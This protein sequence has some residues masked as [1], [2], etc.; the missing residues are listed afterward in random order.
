M[1]AWVTV[2]DRVVATEPLE[3]FMALAEQQNAA[4]SASLSTPNSFGTIRQGPAPLPTNHWAPRL[5]IQHMNDLLS[6]GPLSQ[7][8]F[9][10]SFVEKFFSHELPVSLVIQFDAEQTQTAHSPEPFVHKHNVP[11]GALVHF[12]DT[13]ARSGALSHLHFDLAQSRESVLSNGF[14]FFGS[15]HAIIESVLM[16]GSFLVRQQAKIRIIFNRFGMIHNMELH[17]TSHDEY[18]KSARAG[19]LAAVNFPFGVDRPQ[20]LY[21]WGF[22]AAVH[23]CLDTLSAIMEMS[24]FNPSYHASYEDDRRAV[25][26]PEYKALYAA[27]TPSGPGGYLDFLGGKMDISKFKHSK[28]PQSITGGGSSPKA[29]NRKRHSNPSHDLSLELRL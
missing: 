11:P 6:A 21:R 3:N 18:L 19:H 16:D 13:W 25:I 9:W 8:D 24:L 26:A 12:F 1:E 20:I 7:A 5:Q 14:I 23:R 28:M 22:P 4:F 27:M 2:G 29:A 10:R 17:V 15:L